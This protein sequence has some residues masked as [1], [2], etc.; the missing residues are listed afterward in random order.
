MRVKTINKELKTVFEN[1][2]QSIE[3]EP[4]RDLVKRN[5]VITGGCIAS[6]LLKEEVND[7][8]MYFTNRETV[9]AVTKYYVQKF[10]TRNRLR[11][12][13]VNTLVVENGSRVKIN[14]PDAGIL[15]GRSSNRKFIPIGLTSNSITLTGGV[16]LVIR[17]YGTVEEIHDTFDFAHTMN[18]WK[19]STGKVT[20]DPEALECLITK[21]LRYKGSR[22]PLCSIIRTRKFINRGFRINAGQYLKMAMQLNQLDLTD[23]VT[24]DDQLTGVDVAYFSDLVSRVRNAEAEGQE[25]GS[26]FIIDLVDDIFDNP[27]STLEEDDPDDDYN[28]RLGL[29]E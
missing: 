6:M 15:R 1:F 23:V 22:Y 21:E 4:V 9:L 27:D 14:C 18:Y 19:S 24:L 8:D 16:Q 10:I 11:T 20:L 2:L 7:Y 29:T 12:L 3:S 5:T 28:E 25:I 26:H 13:T 17:F